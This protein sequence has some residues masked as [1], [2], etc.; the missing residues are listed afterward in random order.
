MA[1][2]KDYYKELKKYKDDVFPNIIN[3]LDEKQISYTLNR[4]EEPSE[5]IISDATF[6]IDWLYDEVLN[7]IPENIVSGLISTTEFLGIYHI[8]LRLK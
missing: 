4:N 3:A 8:R 2:L 6:S 5:I 1:K 7:Y